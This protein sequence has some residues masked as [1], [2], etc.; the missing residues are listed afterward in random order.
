[1]DRKEEL[2][3]ELQE[4]AARINKDMLTHLRKIIESLEVGN[5]CEEAE[6]FY[7][8]TS[9]K[10]FVQSCEEMLELIN[11]IKIK[12]IVGNQP[13]TDDGLVKEVKKNWLGIKKLNS[14]MMKN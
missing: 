6:C 13:C 11:L 12:V 1:M 10:S 2:Q 9:T 8:N 14:R 4:K 7:I 5:G 3:K